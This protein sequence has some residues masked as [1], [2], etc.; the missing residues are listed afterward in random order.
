MEVQEALKTR[1]AY[2]SLEPFPVTDSLLSSLGEAA[3]LAP[4]CSN[5]PP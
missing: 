5:S 3:Q 1:R 2:R 4:S